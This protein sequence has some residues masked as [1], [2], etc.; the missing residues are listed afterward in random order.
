MQEWKLNFVNRIKNLT[1]HDLSGEKYF[2]IQ[3]VFRSIRK[4]VKEK[5]ELRI[6]FYVNERSKWSADS[7]FNELKKHSCIKTNIA[8]ANRIEEK[9]D[10]EN[11]QFFKKIDKDLIVLEY[12][13][14]EYQSLLEFNPDIVFYQQPWM[15]G[16]K[17]YP[18]NMYKHCLCVYIPYGFILAENNQIHYY[19][20]FHHSL[21]K[22]FV[23]NKE[24]KKLI[25]KMNKQMSKTICNFG[26]PKLDVYFNRKVKNTNTKTVIYAPHWSV[27][28]SFLLFSTFHKNK[29]F[30]LKVVKENPQINWIYKP[31][32][33]LRTNIVKQGFM[34]EEEYENYEKEWNNLP[35]AKVIKDGNYFDLFINSDA[36]ITDSVSFLAEYLPTGKPIIHLRLEQDSGFNIIAQKIIKDYY[37]VY[38]EE[39]F[40]EI[41]KRVVI[42]GDDFL[43]KK[44]MKALKYLM[45][46]KKPACE[47]ITN[48][49]LKTFK[50]YKKN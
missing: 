4:K 46:N 3:K 12:K 35:N 44:R 29:D 23:E 41:F 19:T 10:K 20:K 9:D 49:I 31:H 6:I 28:G 48:Y 40:N 26:Y 11:I 24:E 16:D 7:L 47:N 38:N 17:N 43:Y 33:A 15:N 8:L 45:D 34:T 18:S 27:P 1:Y 2:Y 37:K 22:Y 25:C 5:G 50:P 21:W 32:E 30:F 39:E 13:N 36:L 42:D 14:G